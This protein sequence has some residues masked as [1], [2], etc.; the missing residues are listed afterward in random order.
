[1]NGGDLDR[2]LLLQA[3][4]DQSEEGLSAMEEALVTLEARPADDEALHEIFRICHTIKGDAA[5]LGFP[6]LS[7][8]THVLE[9]LLEH[10]RSGS[11]TL[12]PDLTTL[13]LETV[14]AIREMLEAALQGRE[15][16]RR[17][18]QQ[19]LRRVREATGADS[20]EAAAQSDAPL[21]TSGPREPRD[22]EIEGSEELQSPSRVSTI[23]VRV[24]TLDRLLDLV[25]EI[26]IS[27]SHLTQMLGPDEATDLDAL[28]EVHH[29]M[30]LLFSNLQREAMQVRMVPVGPL[31]RQ[32]FRTVRDAAL[33]CGKRARLEIEG[34]DVELDTTVIEHLREP[35]LHMARNAIAHGIETPEEREAT[36]KDP[37]GCIVLRAYHEGASIVVEMGDD[38]AGLDREGIRQRAEAC[39]LKSDTDEFTEQQLDGLIFEAGFSTADNAT[40]TSGR[41]V[42]MDVVRRNIESLRG[43]ISVRSS[44]GK[45][46]TFSIR[47]PLTLA[48]IDGFAVGVRDDVYIIPMSAVIECVDLPST[49]A[50]Q[51]SGSG[52]L[53]LRGSAL[54]YVQLEKALGGGASTP[55]RKTVVVIQHEGN[56]AGI[57]VDTLYGERQAVIKPL[58]AS[59]RRIPGVAGATI[60][61][62]GHVA[63]ILD[64]PALLRANAGWRSGEHTGE[65]RAD[66]GSAHTPWD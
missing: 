2:D 46:T 53:D 52:I 45:G 38:G 49:D 59:M 14:D 5:S 63:L 27:R 57:A 1:M 3:F 64:V 66:G 19:L 35:L 24:D 21:E 34:G 48:I 41:G 7:K 43:S 54:P 39:G 36:G 65:F 61:G 33:A 11:V 50:E 40:L 42:G 30:D 16:S 58:D 25:G 23:R 15:R 6:K 22:G 4:A 18:H 20:A 31:F 17:K 28:R 13:L 60:L 56:R 12:T 37:E 26:S 8:F 10:V 9:D 29:E 47:V 62:D 44:R 32:Q 51:G 55:T